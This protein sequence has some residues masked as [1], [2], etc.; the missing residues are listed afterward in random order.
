MIIAELSET[1]D[2]SPHEQVGDVGSHVL[3]VAIDAAFGDVNQ[4]SAVDRGDGC[5]GRIWLEDVEEESEN[6]R[7]HDIDDRDAIKP[8]TE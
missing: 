8:E 7:R 2:G 6:K 1:L 4:A 3:G 5:F